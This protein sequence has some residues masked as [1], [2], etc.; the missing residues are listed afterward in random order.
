MVGLTYLAIMDLYRLIYLRRKEKGG[1]SSC[2]REKGSA[3]W[4]VTIARRGRCRGYVLRESSARLGLP[5]DST[6]FYVFMVT[7]DNYYWK[8]ATTAI[9]PT[10]DKYWSKMESKTIVLFSLRIYIDAFVQEEFVPFQ[11][12]VGSDCLEDENEH[13][14]QASKIIIHRA[15]ACLSRLKLVHQGRFSL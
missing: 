6:L 7:I 13:S 10:T 5:V 8:G 4:A 12:Y 1:R 3:N 2:N 15:R 9:T 11:E 14:L